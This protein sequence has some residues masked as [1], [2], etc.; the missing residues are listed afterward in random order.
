MKFFGQWKEILKKFA[1]TSPRELHFF[2]GGQ[3]DFVKISLHQNTKINPLEDFVDLLNLNSKLISIALTSKINT[4]TLIPQA[5][6]RRSHR[7]CSIKKWVLRNFAKFTEKLLC[8][9]FFFNKVAG[10]RAASLLKKK[11][12]GTGEFCEIYKNT[13]FTEHLRM[14]ASAYSF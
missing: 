7:A 9:S 13:F 6:S 1:K 4:G 8:Q 10:L 12:S 3:G 14:T 5:I 11:G 2:S